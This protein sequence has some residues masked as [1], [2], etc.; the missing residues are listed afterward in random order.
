MID[1]TI[2]QVLCIKSERNFK[3][4]IQVT[5]V[6]LIPVNLQEEGLLK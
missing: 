5:L 4:N 6:L 3:I 2:F 1:I